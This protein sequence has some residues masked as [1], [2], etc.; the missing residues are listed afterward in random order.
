[1]KHTALHAQ[2]QSINPIS[3]TIRFLLLFSICIFLSIFALGLS[4]GDI[5]FV[6][7]SADN[8]GTNAIEGIS[9]VAMQSIPATTQIVFSDGEGSITWTAPGTAIDA[10]T[11]ITLSHTQNSSI[12]ATIGSVVRSG[13]NFNIADANEAIDAVEDAGCLAGIANNIA[14]PMPNCTSLSSSYIVRISGDEDVMVYSGPTT[15]NGTLAECIA[16]IA[17]PANWSTEDGTGDQS[18]NGIYPDFPGDVPSSFTGSALPVELVSFTSESTDNVIK[19]I[20]KTASELNNSHF[21]IER[22][23]TGSAFHEIARVKGHGTTYETHRY[24]FTDSYPTPGTNYYRLK[25]VDYD[26]NFTY[27]PVVEASWGN[28]GQLCLY[29]SPV[30][31]ELHIVLPKNWQEKGDIYIFNSLGQVQ[32]AGHLDGS[33]LETTINVGALPPGPYFLETLSGHMRVVQRFVKR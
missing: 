28:E 32:K 10:G 29:P 25:Q 27:S 12:S 23:S 6:G 18:N 24:T 31:S 9:F 30:S 21:L 19:L 1:M 8:T 33:S 22:S 16:M 11:V 5:M 2:P 4:N 17:N 13:G 7:F 14:E 26:G 15:C 3:K 20:W